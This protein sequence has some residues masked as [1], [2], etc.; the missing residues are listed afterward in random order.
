M[1]PLLGRAFL[2]EFNEG[3]LVISALTLPGTSLTES[4]AMGRRLEEIMLE[5][6]AVV[7]TARRTGRA[8]L[9]EHAQ[10]VNAAEIDVRLDLSGYD[11]ETVLE[12]LRTELG[13]VP[14]TQITIGQP[15]GH[16]IDH[17]L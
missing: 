2:P 5:H 11:M 8:E 17:M 10:G 4:D 12:E 16:R 3:T 14:G 13:A 6:P 1:V 15:I 9:D 7:E